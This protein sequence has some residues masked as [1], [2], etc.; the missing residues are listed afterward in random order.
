MKILLTGASGLVGSAFAQ[1]ATRRGHHVTGLVGTFSGEIPGVATKRTADLTDETALMGTVL[2]VF[3]D[4]IVNC[5]AVSEPVQCDADPAR[6][7]ALNVALP[8]LLARLANH[9]SARL[10]HLSS[11]QVFD[12]ASDDAYTV[13]HPV[14]PIN[15]YGRQK[16]ESERLVHTA[17]P[18]FAITLRAPLLTG[19][20]LT[21]KRSLHERL[22]ADWSAGKTPKVYTDEIRQPCT[23]ANLAEIMVEL[24]ER[25]DVRGVFHWAGADA[26]SRHELA[27]RIRA[28]FKLSD[29]AAPLEPVTRSA[30]PRAASKRQ[31]SLALDLK[32]LAGVVKT[33]IETFDAQLD[34]FIIPPAF[35]AWYFS[36]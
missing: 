17:A 28:H 36:A 3:P 18:E 7:Q 32:P 6:A 4:A 1:A 11:E 21:G 9:L 16:A 15:L 31:A 30:D 20:S 22:F 14:K 29:T 24:L 8:A 26:L 35:R 27:R 19:N 34:Q 25:N 13:K 12:G 23:A 5:A 10:I 2:E 33:P